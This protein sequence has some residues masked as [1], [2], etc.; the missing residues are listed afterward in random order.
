[1]RTCRGG[2]DKVGLVGVGMVGASFAYALVQSGL[3][4]ELILIDADHARAEGDGLHR[5]PA[6]HEGE[7]AGRQRSRRQA[8]HGRREVV[9]KEAPEPPHETDQRGERGDESGREGGGARQVHGAGY[10]GGRRARWTSA[11]STCSRYRPPS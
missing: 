6:T 11:S 8:A 4:N 2:G 5:L 7:D 3:A 10:R 9:G 1:M